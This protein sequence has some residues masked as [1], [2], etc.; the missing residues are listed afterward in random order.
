MGNFDITEDYILFVNESDSSNFKAERVGTIVGPESWI[1]YV[2]LTDVKNNIVYKIDRN[3]PTPYI[4]YKNKLY[5]PDR[6]NVLCSDDAKEAIYSE[7]EL[8]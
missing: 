4:I 5:I 7:Y 2:K 3:V 1:S 6:Y 8:K